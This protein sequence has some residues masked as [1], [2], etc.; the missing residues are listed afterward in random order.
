MMGVTSH[1]NLN[2]L[3]FFNF[4]LALLNGLAISKEKRHGSALECPYS[5]TDINNRAT[6]LPL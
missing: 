3:V 4:L 1:A 2:K 6:A 5:S